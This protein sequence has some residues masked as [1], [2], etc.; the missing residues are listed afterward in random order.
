[1]RLA[2]IENSAEDMRVQRM[3]DAAKQATDKAKQ[4]TLQADANATQLKAKQA[5]QKLSQP[6]AS[7]NAMIKPHA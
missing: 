3:R 6:N 5:R 4:V 1:M 2:E 7:A